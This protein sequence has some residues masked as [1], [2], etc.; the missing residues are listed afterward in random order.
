MHRFISF[1]KI[2]QLLIFYICFISV[3]THMY[4][5]TH[6]Y[7]YSLLFPDP[8]DSVMH[9]NPSPLT[10]SA[11]FFLRT[12]TFSCS[13]TKQNL[14]FLFPESCLLPVFYQHSRTKEAVRGIINSSHPLPKLFT[15]MHL[16]ETKC[17]NERQR[18]IFK[19]K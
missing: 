7:Y 2:H 16:P 3:Y 5:C 9:H 12:I 1:T 6:A 15:T 18:L 14:I 17:E 10:A 11:M 4:I 13:C 8:F 19:P